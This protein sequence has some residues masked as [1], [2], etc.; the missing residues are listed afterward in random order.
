MIVFEHC[1]QAAQRR[2]GCSPAVAS[3]NGRSFMVQ[4]TII[5]DVVPADLTI[6]D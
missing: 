6:N 3:G 4:H 1:S 5:P 2:L